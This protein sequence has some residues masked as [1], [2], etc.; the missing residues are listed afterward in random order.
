MCQPQQMF[1]RHTIE[2]TWFSYLPTYLPSN[3]VNIFVTFSSQL[4]GGSDEASSITDENENDVT[5]VDLHDLMNQDPRDNDL[6]Q[7][8]YDLPPHQRCAPHTLNLVASK[9]VDKHLSTSSLSRNVYRSAFAKCVALWN[10]AN[11]STL[12]AEK[13]EEKLKKKLLVPSPRWNSYFDAICKVIENLL[14]DINE[15]C[16]SIELRGFSEKDLCFLQEY[17]TA[18]KPLIGHS[19]RRGLLLLWYVA[20]YT[21]NNL[22]KTKASIPKLS[23]MTLVLLMPL[24]VQLRSDLLA[25]SIPKMP[26]LLQWH[27]QNLN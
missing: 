23:I 26:S 8:E 10:K 1:G 14:S 21:G 17:V 15:V 25:S 6:T 7:V 13:V 2:A 22:Q 3:F 20:S 9:D 11:R 5:F 27:P 4:A 18:L 19:P 24:I 12:A 16:C